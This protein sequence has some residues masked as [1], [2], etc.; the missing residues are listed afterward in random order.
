M[1]IFASIKSV[2]ILRTERFCC[3]RWEWADVMNFLI[4]IQF[5]LCFFV[6]LSSSSFSS[7][8][9]HL[10]VFIRRSRLF[11]ECKIFTIKNIKWKR[12]FSLFVVIAFVSLP[13]TDFHFFFFNFFVSEVD[14]LFFSYF[15][16]RFNNCTLFLNAIQSS[17]SFRSFI[18]LFFSLS[19][20]C[21]M[22]APKVHKT[23]CFF[24]F[25]FSK[26]KT[27]YLHFFP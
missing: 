17:F 20:L 8:F 18:E 13:S 10:I 7:I 19:I 23:Y 3:R 16:F 12:V 27:K 11:C 6:C 26:T 24:Y 4:H 2:S 1:C 15:F 5:C 21:R 22:R 25:F 9:R 14:S